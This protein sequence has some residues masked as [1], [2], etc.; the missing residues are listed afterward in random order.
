MSISLLLSKYWIA[1]EFLVPLIGLLS[2]L[3]YTSFERDCRHSIGIV[4]SSL[5]FIQRV[6]RVVR[7]LTAGGK[8][9]R[10]FRQIDRVFRFV[11]LPRQE[12]FSRGILEQRHIFKVVSPSFFS[13]IKSMDLS[14]LL[15]IFSALRDV[16][17]VP[18][19]IFFI[20]LIRYIQ[21]VQIH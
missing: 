20:E 18:L 3:K 19:S 7:V 16:G 15:P 11:K 13:V 14:L 4:L 2:R 5:W 17:R 12:N 21:I 10:L 9:V 1:L 6:T 8:T